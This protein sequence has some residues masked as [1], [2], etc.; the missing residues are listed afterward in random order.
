MKVITVGKVKLDGE[1]IDPEEIIEI[2]DKKILKHLLDAGAVAPL[3]NIQSK[4]KLKQIPADRKDVIKAL[5][6]IKVVDEKIAEILF[7]AGYTSI[8]DIGDCSVDDLKKIKG[9]SP[10][11]AQSIY[12]SFE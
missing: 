5:T 8:N 4:R 3:E 9:I 7:K 12:D 10:E 6:T 11:L 2:K 1:Y